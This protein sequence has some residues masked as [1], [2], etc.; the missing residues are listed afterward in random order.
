MLL[1]KGFSPSLL[2]PFPPPLPLSSSSDLL[3]TSPVKSKPDLLGSSHSLHTHTH[4]H[5]SAF[6]FTS[7]HAISPSSVDG[8][9]K[10][11]RCL[12]Q[13]PATTYTNH[14]DLNTQTRN[15][16]FATSDPSPQLWQDSLTPLHYATSSR[17]IR[18][19]IASIVRDLPP[20][21][22]SGSID[23][24]C[25]SSRSLPSPTR[26]DRTYS[27]CTVLTSPGPAQYQLP[28]LPYCASVTPLPWSPRKGTSSG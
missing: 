5:I 15:L 18:T 7:F 13:P 9:T 23:W 16:I 2:S 26:P 3:N 28:P 8:Q 1:P 12:I 27:T 25:S 4:R 14:S 22:Q 17:L 10:R 6:N 20:G 19:L 24:I 11:R 21:H